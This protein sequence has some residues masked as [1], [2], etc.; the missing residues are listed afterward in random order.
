MAGW[1]TRKFDCRLWMTRLEYLKCRMLVADTGREAPEDAIRF[2]RAAGWDEEAIDTYKARFG[3]FG[4]AHP[5]SCR[6]AIRRIGD[7]ESRPDRRAR[8]AGGGRGGPLAG[9]RLPLAARS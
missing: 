6:T 7:G 9:A 8:L 5:C 1:L 2:Y 3:G 4:R